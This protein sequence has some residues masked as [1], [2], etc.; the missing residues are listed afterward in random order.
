MEEEEA[1]DDEDGDEGGGARRDLAHDARL[2]DIRGAAEERREQARY[3]TGGSVRV[4]VVLEVRAA[5][6]QLLLHL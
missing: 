3:D 4:H 2:G 5:Q 1:G 6:H